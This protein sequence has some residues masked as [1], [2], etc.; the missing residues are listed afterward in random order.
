[1]VEAAKMVVVIAD[2]TK[3][4]VKQFLEGQQKTEVNSYTTSYLN[5]HVQYYFDCSQVRPFQ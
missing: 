2:E 4:Q 5:S 3:E 1:M